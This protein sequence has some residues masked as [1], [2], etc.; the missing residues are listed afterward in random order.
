MRCGRAW[1]MGRLGRR[2]GSTPAGLALVLVMASGAGAVERTTPLR[3]DLTSVAHP[4][5]VG[6]HAV[7]TATVTNTGA[8]SLGEVMVLLSLM[9][10]SGASAVPLGVEDW[11]P[12]PEAGHVRR[13]EPGH[14]VARTWPLRMVQSGRLAVFATAVVNDSG[15]VT[16]SSPITWEIAPG[17]NLRPPSVLPTIIGVPLVTMA[18]Y[19]S[20]RRRRRSV[21]TR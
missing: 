13:L 21:Q 14:T 10:R 12:T 5:V 20:L 6:D 11:T 3:I 18:G 2:P 19:A 17:P 7:I 4:R 16:N 9:D 1:S 8:S 15:S